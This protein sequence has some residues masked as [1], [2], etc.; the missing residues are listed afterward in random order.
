[1]TLS[2]K[3][4]LINARE[5]FAVKLCPRCNYA[6]ETVR[7]QYKKN[8]QVNYYKDFPRTGLYRQICLTCKQKEVKK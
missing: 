8:K 1:M 2:K 6:Y 3:D 4:K 7:N 5:G